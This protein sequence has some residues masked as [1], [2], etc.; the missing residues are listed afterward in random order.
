MGPRLPLRRR[1]P[2]RRNPSRAA[3]PRRRAGRGSPPHGRAPERRPPSQSGGRS[4]ATRGAPGSR[5]RAWPW[6]S[7]SLRP[8]IDEPDWLDALRSHLVELSDALRL[9]VEVAIELLEATAPGAHVGFELALLVV[10]EVEA[11]LPELVALVPG[12]LFAHS[13]ALTLEDLAQ[14][15]LLALAAPL[16]LLDGKRCQFL[17]TRLELGQKLL[18]VAGGRV[19]QLALDRLAGHA[20]AGSAERALEEVKRLRLCFPGVCLKPLLALR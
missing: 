16:E 12:E 15:F 10:V 3:A 8:E 19:E 13:L 20:A 7:V 14:V 6:R 18:Y 5:G 17:R 4:R 9:T 11:E 1:C 2:L